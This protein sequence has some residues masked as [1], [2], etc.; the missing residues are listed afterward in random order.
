MN[1]QAMK[2]SLLLLLTAMIWGMGFVA[3]GAGMERVGA[4]TFHGV[5]SLVGALVLLVM[6]GIRRAKGGQPAYG[7]KKML[8]AAGVL[9]GL[10]MLLGSILQMMGQQQS[11]AGKAG[12]ITALYILF[13]PIIG[14][15]FR[16]RVRLMFWGLVLLA[17]GG[18]YLLCVK[19]DLS[20]GAGD[21]MVL[22]CAVMFAIHILVID[23]FS[24][25]VD[26]VMFSGL[27]LLINGLLALPIALILEK[28][29]LAQVLSAWM[30]ILY[31]GVLSCAVAFT[32]QVYSQKLVNPV[33]ACLIMSLESV[34]AMLADWLVMGNG[35]TGRELLGAGLVFAAVTLAQLPGK[36]QSAL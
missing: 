14:L 26:S 10:A 25:H 13:V 4:F 6:M 2:G 11:G 23:Y 30:P 27:Q 28:P 33:V 5:R 22:G 15:F 21:V 31:S 18:M 29:T 36:K 17:C 3:Q 16:R 20:V 9:G 32:L 1:R 35:M 24:P 34:F 12:F 19:S 8:V 7:S